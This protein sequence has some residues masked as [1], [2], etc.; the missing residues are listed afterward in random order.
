MEES[1]EDEKI[2]TEIISIL[3]CHTDWFDSVQEDLITEGS[4]IG[5]AE[6]IVE[7][8]NNNKKE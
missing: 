4:F 5:I 3:Y 8:L 7:L 1:M 2:K 6:T